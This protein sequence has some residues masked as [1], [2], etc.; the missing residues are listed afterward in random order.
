MS[1]IHKQ[2]QQDMKR[3][4][5]RGDKEAVIAEI[6]KRARPIVRVQSVLGDT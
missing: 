2:V 6:N 1:T 5:F 3:D 4:G